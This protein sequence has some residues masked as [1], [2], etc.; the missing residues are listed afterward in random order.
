MSLRTAGIVLMAG[1][2]AAPAIAQ[3]SSP[4]SKTAR[5]PTPTATAVPTLT[6]TP[7]MSTSCI[8][9]QYRQFDFWLGE[10]DLVGADG[11][12][13]AEDKVVQ[14]L[15]GCA[16]QE[17]GSSPESGQ[18]M[19][20][21]AYDPATKHWHQMLIDDGGAV[22]RLEGELID[23]RMVLVGQRPSQKEKGVNLTHRITWT[24]LP[25]RRV[26]KS[27]EYSNN[28]GRTWRPF[29]DVTYSPRK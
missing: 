21:S 14:I 8:A 17:N 10:W 7:A 20:V 2:A 18:R 28:G 29:L 24:P 25:D 26:R 4:R 22:L 3:K 13:S 23:G 6:P 15:G 5:T 12:K 19:S 16:L 9:P 1:L 11:K 27:W